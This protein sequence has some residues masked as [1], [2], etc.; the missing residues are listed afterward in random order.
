MGLFPREHLESLNYGIDMQP[1]FDKPDASELL[2]CIIFHG[3]AC[4]LYKKL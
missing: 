1:R 4:S 3:E 2:F